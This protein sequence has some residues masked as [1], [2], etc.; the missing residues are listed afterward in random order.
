MVVRSA[1]RT[2]QT[3]NNQTCSTAGKS[4]RKG[5]IVSS[6]RPTRKLTPI[7]KKAHIN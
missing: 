2:V 5:H 3:E 1:T 7:E 4:Y 6:H